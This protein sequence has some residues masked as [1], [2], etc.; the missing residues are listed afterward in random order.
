MK[1]SVPF[2]FLPFLMTQKCPGACTEHP[3]SCWKLDTNFNALLLHPLAAAACHAGFLVP[4]CRRHLTSTCLQQHGIN[5][6]DQTPCWCE[7]VMFQA[8]QGA[9]S[10]VLAST[11]YWKCVCMCVHEHAAKWKQYQNSHPHILFPASTM[12]TPSGALHDAINSY[13]GLQHNG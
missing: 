12:V 10:F 6:R 3:W 4:V 1:V 7:G 11:W 13:E 8:H 5:H 9:C 2:N